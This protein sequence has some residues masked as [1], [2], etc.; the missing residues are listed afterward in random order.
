MDLVGFRGRRR[1]FSIACLLIGGVKPGGTLVDQLTGFQG[2]IYNR[3]PK[4][5]SGLSKVYSTNGGKHETQCTEANYILDRAFSGCSRFGSAIRHYRRVEWIRIL[6]RVHRICRSGS[7][8]LLQRPINPRV[9]VEPDRR[10]KI[11]KN[12]TAYSLREI[13]QSRRLFTC[14]W[15]SARALIRFLPSN[16]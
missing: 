12:L 5:L 15:Y 10:D 16:R 1:A 13:I 4:P 3:N 8:Q 2:N 9:V 7:W 14:F 6:V 11:S